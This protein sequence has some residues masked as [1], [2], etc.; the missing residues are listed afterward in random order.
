MWGEV[1]LWSVF[2]TGA[3]VAVVGLVIVF[4]RGRCDRDE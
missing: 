4:F 3:Y 2:L 1:D